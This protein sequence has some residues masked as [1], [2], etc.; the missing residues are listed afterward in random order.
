MKICICTTPIR[1]HPTDYPPFGS[2]AIIQSLRKI[3][4]EADFYNIDYFR[5][6]E[7]H[8]EK[9]F[10]DGGVDI[11]GISAVVST[12][13]AYVKYLSALIKRVSPKTRVVVGGNLAASAEI[14]LRKCNVD[15]CVVGDGEF[16]IRDVVTSIMT[17]GFNLTELDKISG[18]C[19]LNSK[20]AF[21]FTGYGRKPTEEELEAPDYSILERDGSINHFI[22]GQIKER[23]FGYDGEDD[24]K[25]AFATVVMSKGCV[26]RCT[27][28]HRWERGFRPLPV[29]N[30][31]AHIKVLYDKYNV[32]FIQVADENFGSNKAQA[33]EMAEE[34]NKLGIKWQVAGVRTNTVTKGIL[35]HWRDNGC[36]TVYYGIE[37]GSQ[38]ILDVMEKKTTVEQN[39]NALKWTGEVG[40][41]TIVQ[42]VLGMPGETDETID[43]TI[44]FLKKISPY[45]KQWDGKIASSSLSINYAQALPGTPLY[46]YQRLKGYIGKDMDSE[47]QYLIGI[48]DTDAYKEDHFVNST[49]LPMLKVLMWRPYMLAQLDVHH[50]KT[51]TGASALGVT[52]IVSYYA[53]IIIKRFLKI[54]IGANDEAKFGGHILAKA[55][56]SAN[57]Y[58]NIHSGFKFAPMLLNPI[59]R[60]FFKPF[61]AVVVGL[62]NSSSPIDFLKLN[63][64][65]LMWWLKNFVRADVKIGVGQPT[66]SLR[67]VVKIHA[68]SQALS[69]SEMDELRAGR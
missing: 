22:N 55:D 33:Y 18:I 17:H 58:F 26:A 66:E 34:L 30:L 14:L 24:G 49:G 25:K 65:Y 12:A 68:P 51:Q 46:E 38:R 28:C 44:E 1:P 57:G 50:L 11:V 61:L 7:S 6:S 40:L 2:L 67:R 45:I 3:G 39:I 9:H 29:G 54:S 4:I 69:A 20:D 36:L 13:Y 41:N 48:S 62:R 16:I 5:Y 19:F 64:E 31:M 56:I 32:R 35:Q 23:F 8:I 37:S 42:L 43:E 53:K 47:E 63:I 59:T 10:A 21:R 60:P 52:R 27:F 15:L